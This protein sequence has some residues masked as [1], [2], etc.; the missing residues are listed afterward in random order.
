MI[1]GGLVRHSLKLGEQPSAN[2]NDHRQQQ[3]F[4][5]GRDH[6]AQHLLGEKGGLVPQRKGHQHE[7][8]EGGQLELDQGHEQLNGQEEETDDDH[9]PGQKQHQDA[10]QIAENFGKTAE[11]ADLLKQRPSGINAN[12]GQPPWLQKLRVTQRR[13]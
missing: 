2:A 6:I 7:A 13:T 11:A 10:M 9:Q 5:A 3:H 8:C 1:Y 4:D 12:R